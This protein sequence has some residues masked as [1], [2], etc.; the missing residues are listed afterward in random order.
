MVPVRSLLDQIWILICVDVRFHQYQYW[1]C[2]YQMRYH[3][4]L[5]SE[6]DYNDLV[7]SIVQHF[8]TTMWSF[9][10]PFSLCF[11]PALNFT[12]I[13]GMEMYFKNQRNKIKLKQNDKT[14]AMAYGKGSNVWRPTVMWPIHQHCHHASE[15]KPISLNRQRRCALG[16]RSR[17]GW[18]GYIMVAAE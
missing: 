10:V 4:R 5:P 3:D 18:N 13:R 15:I 7:R 17:I 11:V 8:H 12:E 16:Q 6:L 9:V 14:L 1:Y 2:M